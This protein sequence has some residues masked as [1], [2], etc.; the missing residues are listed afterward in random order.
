MVSYPQPFAAFNGTWM[1]SDGII[2]DFS[3][4]GISFLLALPELRLGRVYDTA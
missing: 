1:G 2:F 4:Y 3:L